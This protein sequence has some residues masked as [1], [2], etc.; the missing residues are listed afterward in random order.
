MILFLKLLQEASWVV[1][2]KISQLLTN[3]LLQK[4]ESW[5]KHNRTLISSCLLTYHALV[6]LTQEL[7][8]TNARNLAYNLSLVF[9]TIY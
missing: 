8:L 3:S 4:L 5:M 2:K 9:K 6:G 7:S 1:L